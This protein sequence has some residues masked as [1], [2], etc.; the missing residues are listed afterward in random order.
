MSSSLTPIVSLANASGV[1]I[2]L[3]GESRAKV[4]VSVEPISASGNGTLEH[5][6][7]GGQEWHPVVDDKGDAIT[8]WNLGAVQ[9][10]TVEGGFS[11]IRVSSTSSSDEFRLIVK[12]L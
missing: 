11:A 1:A 6:P 7:D 3:L 5:M 9:S 4:H 8:G 10:A 2:A 12:P